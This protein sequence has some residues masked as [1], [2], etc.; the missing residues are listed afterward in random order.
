MPHHFAW[1]PDEAAAFTLAATITF[2]AAGLW[3]M[4]K[5]GGLRHVSTF[6]IEVVS[7]DVSEEAIAHDREV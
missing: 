3:R 6:E 1:K 5:H 7:V 2:Y 4:S